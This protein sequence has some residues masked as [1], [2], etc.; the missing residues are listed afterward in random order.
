[1]LSTRRSIRS[2]AVATSTPARKTRHK[3]K[4]ESEVAGNELIGSHTAHKSTCFIDFLD[5]SVTVVI[6][7]RCKNG[8]DASGIASEI[9]LRCNGRHWTHS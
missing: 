4:S 9:A 8:G 2:D 1:M 3:L 5:K 7:C 6:Q